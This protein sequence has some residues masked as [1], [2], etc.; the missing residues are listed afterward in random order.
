[1]MNPTFSLR[2]RLLLAPGAYKLALLLCTLLLAVGALVYAQR[3][4]AQR[5]NVHDSLAAQPEAQRPLEASK[6]YGRLP[7][8]FETNAGQ[9]DRSTQ[10]VARGPGYKLSL[11]STEATL[12]LRKAE[13]GSRN[14][15]S[16]KPEVRSPKSARRQS[17]TRNPQSTVLSMKLVG[18]RATAQAEAQGELPTKSNYLVGND[19]S[20][21]RTNISNYERVRYAEVYPGIDIVYYGNQRQL[22]YDFIVAPGAR[23]QSIRLA[24]SGAERI[25][26][27][28]Q[29]ELVLSLEDGV[30]LRSSKPLVYQETADGGR[31]EVAGRYTLLGRNE[32]GFEL[33]DYDQ[34]RPLVIDPVLVYS[35]YLDFFN[36]SYNSG[37]TTD[38]SNNVYV[39]GS[40]GESVFVG[41]LNPAGTAFVYTTLIGGDEGDT[42]MSIAVDASGNAY[43]SGDAYSND[44]PVVNAFQSVR[45]NEEINV[46]DTFVLKLDPSGTTLLFSTFLGGG[47][48]DNNFGIQ[49]DSSG[50][51]Y[52]TGLTASPASWDPEDAPFPTVNAFQ[53]SNAGS[54]DG[55]L[56]KFNSTGAVVYSTYLGGGDDD[57]A[58]DVAVD[59]AGNVYLTGYTS[60]PDFPKQNPLQP[61]LASVNGDA[62]VTKFNADASALIFS[63]YLGGGGEDLGW[64]IAL[65]GSQNVYL[66]GYTRSTNF[67]KQ[68]PL[69]SAYGGSVDGFVTKLNAAGSALVYSTYLGG[70][71][72][73]ESSDI[74]VNAAGESYVV[75]YTSSANFPTVNPLQS[76]NNGGTD[77]F[78]SKLNAAGTAL[79]FSTYLGGSAAGPTG[80]DADWA[81]GVA[82]D[83]SGNVYMFGETY[84]NN[85][86]TVNAIQPTLPSYESA[87]LAKISES[88]NQTFYTISGRIESNAGN[89]MGDVTVTLSGTQTATAQ[90]SDFG[91]YSFTGLAA[92]GTYTVT[93]TRAGTTFDPLNQTFTNLSADQNNVDFMTGPRTYH[94]NGRVTDASGNGLAGVSIDITGY[95]YPIERVTDAEGNY[96]LMYLEG[97]REYTVTPRH[98]S[99][100]FT[101]LSRTFLLNS[102]Q[103]TNFTA[104]NNTGLSISLT[105]P[106]DGA[107]FQAPAVITLAANAASTNSTITKVEFFANDALVGTDTGAPYS[108]NWTGVAG[109]NYSIHALVTDAAGATKQSNNADIIVNSVN[110]PSVTITNP[111][112]GATFFPGSYIYIT[113]NASSPNGEITRVDFYEGIRLIGSDDTGESPFSSI[114]FLYEGSYALTAVAT[115]STGAVRQSNPVHI[116]VVRNQY[117][118]IQLTSPT[119]GQQFPAGSNITLVA[120]ATDPD[121]TIKQVRF[122]ASG[123]LLRTDLHPPFNYNWLNVQPGDYT[124]VLSAT[125]DQGATSWSNPVDI[126][127]GNR[128]PSVSITSPSSGA[129]YAAPADITL[130]ANALDTDGSISKVEFFADG[131]LVGTDTSVPYSITWTGVAEGD[132]DIVAKATD[133]EGANALST[134]ILVRVFGNVPSV[135]I[136]AP[137]DGESFAAPAT[138]EITADAGSANSTI[139]YVSFYA[140]T[141]HLGNANNPPYSIAWSNVPIGT[142]AITA[143]A[144][145][146]NSA[147]VTSAPV[148]VTVTGHIGNW[149]QQ[150]PAI[151]GDLGILEDVEMVSATDGWAVGEGGTI[152]Y[153][154]DGGLTWTRQT[155]GTTEWLHGVSFFD[156]LHGVAVGNAVLYTTNG[157]LTWS[158][159]TRFGHLG[160]LYGVDFVSLNTAYA[161]G[162]GVIMKTTDGGSTWSPQNVPVLSFRNLVSVDFVNP[163]TGWA[164]GANG[165]IIATTN[166]G[167]NWTLQSSNTNNFFGGVSFVSATEGWTVAGNVVLH[168]T[169]G[170]Q[171]WTQQPV[172]QNTWVAP[173]HFVDALNG[174]AAGTQENI[175]RTSDGGQTWVTQRGGTNTPFIYPFNGVSFGDALHGIAVGNAGTIVSTIDGGVTW[176]PVQGN[177]TSVPNRIFA[178]DGNHAW[179]ANSNAEILSTTDGGSRWSRASLFTPTSNSD[180]TDIDFTD[181]LHGWATVK[182][183]PPGFVYKSSDG[184]L[185]WQNSGAPQ[186]GALQGVEAIGNQAIVAVGWDGN[187]GRILRSTDNGATW[188]NQSPPNGAA[189]FYDV[190][191]I[192]ATTG[193]VAGN[194]GTIM[195]STDGGAT[196]TRQTSGIAQ[197]NVLSV[198]FVDE[199]NGW[200]AGGNSLVHT[201]DGGQTWTAQSAGLDA[202]IYAVHG[203]SP[204]VAW[205]SGYN[206]LVAQTTDGGATWARDSLGTDATFMTCFFPDAENGWVGGEQSG[207]GPLTAGRIYRRTGASTPASPAP[208]T[209]TLTSPADGETFTNPNGITVSASVTTNGRANVSQVDFYDGATLIGTDTTVPYSIL[210]TN[211]PAGSHTIKA[212]AT[213]PARGLNTTSFT[214]PA[215]INVV[216]TINQSPTVSLTSPAMGARFIFGTSINL[217]ANA[218][219]SDGT[220][221]KV[222]FYAGPTLIGT[223]TAS[224]YQMTWIAPAIGNYQLTATAYDNQNATGSNAVNITVS[225]R[226][227]GSLIADFDGD[228]RTDISVFRPAGGYWHIFQSAEG[229]PIAQQWGINNDKPAPGDYDGDS[230]T[231]VAVFRPS[232]GHWYIL[233]SSDGSVIAQSWGLGADIPVAA[234]YDGDGKADLA[235]FRPSDGNWYILKSSDGSFTAQHWGTSEDK[236][237]PGDYDGDGKADLAVFRPSARIW[238]ILRSSD[239]TLSAQSWGLSSDKPVAADYDGDGKTDLAVF[240]PTNGNWYILKSSDG[241]NSAQQWG[242]ST[243][244]PAPG[245]YDG[246]GKTD[247]GVFRSSSGTFYI[248][249]STDNTMLAAQWGTNGDL[250]A[251]SAYVP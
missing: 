132:Y 210:W 79:V 47:E 185:T 23:P 246:D 80:T 45:A 48:D 70:S 36:Y 9:A 114:Y 77:A 181:N 72:T 121:G 5:S 201:T 44:F 191:F 220:I 108:F 159:G 232:D 129:Q 65:D 100:S 91:R 231:D 89:P 233:R 31:H 58:L 170:G 223:D 167:E 216:S 22:E 107:T 190:N 248:L 56:T 75:G 138:I 130:N 35:T 137:N 25:E 33:G 76:S 175:I 178:L 180:V 194:F 204:T 224:P 169:N 6:T 102:N 249:K 112:D 103:T 236:P 52:V 139:S 162:G 21:W 203:V 26:I 230:K 37:I 38:S 97:N 16:P 122:W 208:L 29:G 101:P 83:A 198:S 2:Q 156:T 173:I 247:I 221:S 197:G 64:G 209:I 207:S 142:Y 227:A 34:T 250:P 157:G 205:I 127:V 184:G 110:G 222:E 244:M 242:L 151:P 59:A 239:N 183:G 126:K 228:G 200:A 60:S 174:W 214:N 218:A 229:T 215:N 93:P 188:S 251:P 109:G 88:G 136:T 78:I 154:P 119:N 7:L 192:N 111:A 155:S 63:T 118:S 166:G 144:T 168:T 213:V 94:I 176:R 163:N 14:D 238:Y 62:F 87:V 125:D 158:A 104:T 73:E 57:Y 99:Y 145:D 3:S 147:M 71:S 10:F 202:S 32:V 98:D 195:K 61:T 115:D 50:N 28:K 135:S 141:Q 179:S 69:Q 67:P 243:D 95:Y 134:F 17:A 189:I 4:H 117:P 140:G 124:I 153:T 30:A 39:T 81:S 42:G 171:T 54:I 123:T 240:R 182:E 105:S 235:V 8:S 74:F 86:P 149:H 84:S 237:A 206:G 150:V 19:S 186:T 219:D 85:F 143:V 172:P 41:K 211:V 40:D 15:R 116:T 106:A 177:Y 152:L 148:N 27:G 49:L 66:T 241:S 160:T 120:D 196:W 128:K 24:F 245:D 12:T 68:N 53:S 92:G 131:T 18:A 1:M 46:A 20:K 13:G 11:K 225:Q 217:A 164:V 55:Y 43:V 113:A 187:T 212:R 193:W 82:V 234:D 96:V 226:S 161:S 199:N 90:T 51:A 133:N 165:S 146:Q